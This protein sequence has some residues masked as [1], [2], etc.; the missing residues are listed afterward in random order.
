MIVGDIEAVS[1]EDHRDQKFLSVPLPG[2]VATMKSVNRKQWV[3]TESSKW[4]ET[5]V[6]G[7]LSRNNASSLADAKQARA[8]H[9]SCCSSDP[10]RVRSLTRIT[11]VLTG[12]RRKRLVLL[13]L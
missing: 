4:L 5:T 3:K 8:A 9:S 7:K 13:D 1:I 11:I 10:H 6:D 2:Y 12:P